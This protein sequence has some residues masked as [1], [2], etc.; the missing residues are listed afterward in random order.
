MY[1]IALGNQRL[2][3][4]RSVQVNE[5]IKFVYYKTVSTPNPEC[6]AFVIACEQN[7]I[8]QGRNE[9]RDAH[10]SLPVGK[11][12]RSASVGAERISTGHPAS[13]CALAARI[14]HGCTHHQEEYHHEFF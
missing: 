10:S 13:L 9:H 2:R 1:T 3:R 11:G 7:R 5:L 6:C 4:M 12:L 14:F 8:C